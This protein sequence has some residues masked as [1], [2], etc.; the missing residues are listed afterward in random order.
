MQQGFIRAE[1]I[2]WDE[3]VASGGYQPARERGI[4]R[5]EGRDYPLA[6]GEVMLVKF[7]A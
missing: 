2:A 6:D 5:L 7:R 3:L 4:L 1:V